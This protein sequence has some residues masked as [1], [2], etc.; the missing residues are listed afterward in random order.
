[1]KESHTKIIIIV[2]MLICTGM[3]M[4]YSTSAIYASQKYQDYLYIFKKSLM[5]ISLSIMAFIGGYVI[6]YRT[7]GKCSLFFFILAIASLFLIFTPLGY[8]AG[9]ARRWINLHFFVF[10]PSE[11][12]KY[13]SVLFLSYFLAQRLEKR[14]SLGGFFIPALMIIGFATLP[15]FIEPDFGTSVLIGMVGIII[16]IVAGVRIRH[17][18]FLFFLSLPAVFLMIIREPYRMKRILVF[19]DPWKDPLVTGYQII[20]SFLAFQSG[21]WTGLGL[22]ESRQKLFYLPEAHTDFIFS[23]LGEE[24]G[25]GGTSFV[26]LLFFLF[27]FF[28][29]RIAVRAKSPFGKFLAMG[30][31]SMIGLQA[32]LNMGVVTGILPT[33]GLPLPFISYGGTSLM[34]TMAAV[35]V[36]LNIERLSRQKNVRKV[37]VKEQINPDHHPVRMMR[38]RRKI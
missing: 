4:I 13:A 28:G 1:M 11:I 30:L 25:F 5:W 33:K 32:F 16:L 21:G 23:I 27:I 22:G 10:Q 8:E 12:M 14:E 20:Q 35:G 29:F 34:M 19:L 37:V 6:N 36:L 24:F 17:V 15:V 9:G 2:F 7:L 38:E 18:T 26:C 31:V 3:I